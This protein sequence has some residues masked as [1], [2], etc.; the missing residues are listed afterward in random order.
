MNQ[1]D[2]SISTE[3]SY[4]LNI[5]NLLSSSKWVS[6]KPS[7]FTLENEEGLRAALLQ[8]VNFSLNQ[9]GAKDESFREKLNTVKCLIQDTVQSACVTHELDFSEIQAMAKDNLVTGG[10]F[11]KMM[12]YPFDR[13]LLAET[14]LALSSEGLFVQ[15]ED[16]N[17]NPIKTPFFNLKKAIHVL[18]EYRQ[19]KDA[20]ENG[21]PENKEYE[22]MV[23]TILSLYEEDFASLNARGAYKLLNTVRHDLNYTDISTKSRVC[24]LQTTA[25]DI[26]FSHETPPLSSFISAKY[27]IKPS[28]QNRENYK[29]FLEFKNDLYKQFVYSEH[30]VNSEVMTKTD[31]LDMGM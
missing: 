11:K 2:L 27:S 1:S 20:L 19:V 23:K 15:A 28:E 3:L 18:W 16:S 9:L 5:E 8:R 17:G 13:N 22:N 21:I 10:M 14:E 25:P 6:Q 29:E 24:L 12:D 30:E 7:F 31:D 4:L 26:V